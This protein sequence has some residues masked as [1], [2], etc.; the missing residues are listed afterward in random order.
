MRFLFSQ[1]SVS[2]LRR[3]W[4]M[5]WIHPFCQSERLVMD[6]AKRQVHSSSV[7]N[8]GPWCQS[9]HSETSKDQ[10]SALLREIDLASRAIVAENLTMSGYCKGGDWVWCYRRCG[11]RFCTL[12]RI[13]GS[14]V[15]MFS[16]FISRVV[17]PSL[18]EHD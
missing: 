12:E 11:L 7:R 13:P 17:F 1:I 5:H 8:T 6:H 4:G 9:W 10:H 2:E 18:L 16:T 15:L 14:G 3:I